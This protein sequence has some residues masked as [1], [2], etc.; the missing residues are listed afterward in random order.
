MTH[1]AL[2]ISLSSGRGWVRVQSSPANL[3]SR[4]HWL[5]IRMVGRFRTGPPTPP[6]DWNA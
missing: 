5:K 6:V 3:R 1:C 2:G 4:T